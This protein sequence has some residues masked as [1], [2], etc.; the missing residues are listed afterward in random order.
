[1]S[2]RPDNTASDEPL[3]PP[4][5]PLVVLVGPA[6]VGKTTVGRALAAAL[7]LQFVDAD[8][9]HEPTAIERMRRGEPLDEAAR[10]PWLDRV[11]SALDAARPTGLVVACSALRA[12]Y[13]DQLTRGLPRV[14]CFELAVPAEVLRT[15]LAARPDHFFP[16]ELLASQLATLEPLPPRDR[17]D[18][19]AD[20]ATLVRELRDRLARP[21]ARLVDATALPSYDLGEGHP[22]ARDRQQPLFDLLR[23]VRAFG[24]ADLLPSRALNAAELARVH[25][26]DYIECL[27]ATSKALPDDATLARAA[28]H[29]LGAGDQPIA[30]GQHQGAAAIAGGTVAAAEAVLTGECRAAFNPGGGLHHAMPDRAAG[31]C[32]YNDLALA[33]ARAR[34]A[35]VE[36]VLYVDFD[37]HHGDGVEFMFRDDPH[38]LTLSF[39]EDPRVRFPGTGFVEDRGQGAGRGY[40]L[41]VPLAPGTR[42]ESWRATTSAVLR[43]AVASFRPGLIVSQ[44]GCDTHRDDPLATIDCTTAVAH[45]AATLTRELSDRWCDGRWVA[46]G[47]GGYRPYHVLPRAFGLVWSVL[48]DQPLPPDLPA[49]W[50]RRWQAAAG[51]E[52][53]MSWFDEDDA[54]GAGLASAAAATN[55]ATVERLFELVD[56]LSPTRDPAPPIA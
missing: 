35:G 44:H 48:A 13:R 7:E 27:I 42:D 56:W 45:H 33:I 14:R 38:V 21:A 25:H 18:G 54:A 41:N 5:P 47:G 8:D 17:L 50:R 23:Q 37:V 34:D 9:L 10:G 4:A 55:R 22:F 28:A 15:R 53:P 40:A 6:G 16:P 30:E 31:F 26:L 49:A 2:D 29:G 24:A 36:R 12:T 19:T 1:M 32:L 3:D 20:P 51:S 52:L 46:T 43:A 39:H 11:R